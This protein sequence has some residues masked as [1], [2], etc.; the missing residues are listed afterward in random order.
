MFKEGNLE[1]RAL[2][3]E[4]LELVL[5]LEND[6]E[7]WRWGNSNV[8]YS[9]YTIRQY[10]EQNVN[11]I[12][13]DGQLRL[14]VSVNGQAAGL[15]DLINFDARNQRAEVG[16]VLLPS[17]RNKGYGLAALRLLDEYVRDFLHLRQLY[18]FVSVE[19]ESATAL[20]LAAGYKK[21]SR[22][23]DWLAKGDAYVDALLFT[24]L[25]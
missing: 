2:E 22:L 8:P 19:N 4:D 18:A 6:T 3:P 1:L 25:F 10:I 12:Y 23:C 21:A 17:Y 16:I 7:L 24:F 5:Q 14:V 15:V 11:D 13:A 9:R 20:F